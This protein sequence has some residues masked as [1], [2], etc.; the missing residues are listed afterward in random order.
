MNTAQGASAAMIGWCSLVE[1]VVGGWGWGRGWMLA[2]PWSGMVVSQTLSNQLC[3]DRNYA[4]WTKSIW[5]NTT[6]H[7]SH[8]P[9]QCVPEPN[10]RAIIVWLTIRIFM[11]MRDLLCMPPLATNCSCV[12]IVFSTWILFLCGSPAGGALSVAAAHR[13][14]SSRDYRQ[15]RRLRSNHC[16][17][18]NLNI[19]KYRVWL[20]K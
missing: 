8:P 11:G 20:H 9:C 2:G 19:W 18:I 13:H 5:Q 3:V 15:I 14:Y 16:E 12:C 17:N 4:G 7:P 10:N 6:S 1:R